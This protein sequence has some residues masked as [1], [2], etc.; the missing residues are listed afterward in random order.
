VKL[1]DAHDRPTGHSPWITVGKIYHVLSVVLDA[2]SRWWFRLVGD[3]DR[4]VGLFR[5]EQFEVLS[6]RIPE[7]WVIRWST[8]GGTFELS[9]AAW[10]A[11]GFWERY[12]E[13]DQTAKNEFES[14]L[15]RIVQSDP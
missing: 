8:N 15:N 2:H 10:L 7:R 4:D 1:V 9:P 12:F 11:L 3:E 6:A 5:L 13:H 14:E